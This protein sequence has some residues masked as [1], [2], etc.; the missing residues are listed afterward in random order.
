[1]SRNCL[2]SPPGVT[3]RRYD[4][5]IP[6]TSA[7]GKCENSL[8]DLGAVE[9]VATLDTAGSF[10]LLREQGARDAAASP[11]NERQRF[12]DVCSAPKSLRTRN[13]L[14]RFSR[15][16]RE[17]WSRRIVPCKTSLAFA[18]RKRAGACSSLSGARSLRDIDLTRSSLVLRGV[19]WEYI[20]YLDFVV[21]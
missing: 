5:S 14:T 21:A 12:M 16:R 9:T 4:G 7:A 17:A 2:I 8:H 19:P 6:S 10:R 13:K 18:G 3:I 11:A 20:F 1:V 15:L